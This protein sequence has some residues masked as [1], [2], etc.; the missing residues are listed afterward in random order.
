MG[1]AYGSVHHKHPMLHTQKSIRRMSSKTL[2]RRRWLDGCSK[3][4]Y[5]Q[6]T[7]KKWCIFFM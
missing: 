7:C 4:R 6:K 3:R 1:V 5:K 2:N